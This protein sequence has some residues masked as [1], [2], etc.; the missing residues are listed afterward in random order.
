MINGVSGSQNGYP[1]VTGAEKSKNAI[2]GE[3]E[4]PN[5][6]DLGYK[7]SLSDKNW[8]TLGKKE[9]L[10]EEDLRKVEELKKIDKRVHTHEQAH[11]SAAGSYASGGASYDYVTGPDGN[12]YA[13]SGHVNID[14]SREK[15]PEATIIKANIIQKAALAPADPSPAD[16][17]IAANAVKMAMDAQKEIA[18]K[19]KGSNTQDSPDAPDV[20]VSE[21]S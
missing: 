9:E 2:N 18:E 4:S 17:Q 7:L 5:E 14:T 1:L 13:N 8:K 15:T 12:R 19:K 6:E 16:R 20:T 21:S 3:S 10:S 11:L